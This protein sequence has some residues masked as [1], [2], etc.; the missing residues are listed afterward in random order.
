MSQPN[1]LRASAQEARRRRRRMQIEPIL[2]LEVKALLAPYLPIG[3]RNATFTA[4]DNQPDNQ[5]FGSVN[6]TFGD[7]SLINSAAAYVS[8][9]QLTPISTFNGDIVRIEA[10]P[11]G[12][13]GKSLYAITR[14][15]NTAGPPIETG[16]RPGVIYR[17]DPAT[18]DGNVFF[19]LNT[20]L[21][22]VS[23]GTTA[24]NSA[25][26]ATGLVNWYDITFDETGVFDGLPSMFVSSVD[27]DNPLKNAVY[28][29]APDGTFLGLFIAYGDATGTGS[30]AQRPSAIHVPPPE[31]Q[32]FL[33]G[34]IAGSG[35]NNGNEG[36][37]TAGTTNFTG[38]FFDANIVQGA[39][40]IDA[41]PFPAGVS[42]LNLTL[43]PQVGLTSAN[44]DYGS[45]NYAAFT[46][47]GVPSLSGFSF[48]DPGPSGIQGTAGGL[49]IQNNSGDGVA[50]FNF[51]DFVIGPQPQ[52]TVDLA[53]AQADG[54]QPSGIDRFSAVDTPYR[55]FQDITFDHY[56]YFSYGTTV[57]P[58]DGAL[59]TVGAPVFSGSVF[60]SDLA[61]GLAVPVDLPTV[62]G[63]PTGTIVLPVQ[64]GGQTGVA[65]DPANP[66]GPLQLQFAGG[67]LGGRIIRVLPDGTVTPFAEGFNTTAEFESGSFVESSLSITFSAD[68]TTLYAADNDG[69]WQ[70]KSIM[71][72][73]GSTSGSEVGLNDLRSLGVPFDGEGTAV[74]VVDTGI[75]AS[76]PPLRGHVS[77]GTNISTGG[78]G[79]DD[80]G[81]G[82]GHGTPVAGAI[83][84]FVP[85]TTLVPVNTFNPF[86]AATTNQTVFEAMKYVADNP[87]VNDPLQRGQIDRVVASAFGFGSTS[88]FDTEGTAFRQNKQLVIAYKNQ[89]QRMRRLGI[90][91][92]AAAGQFG[93]PN[94]P[95]IGNVN[96]EALPAILNEAISVTGNYSFPFQTGPTTPPTDPAISPLGRRFGSFALGT[97]GLAD[98]LP[99]IAV[100]D[101]TIFEGRLLSAANRSATTDFAAP[102]LDVPTFRREFAGDGNQHNVF[103]ES[104]TSLSSG[105][106]TGSYTLLASALD[107]YSKL[108]V[109]G[110]TVNSYLTSPVGA[111]ALDYNKSF[112]RDLSAYS[113]P[114]GIN[115]ILQWTAVSI[116]DADLPTDET[117]DAR[118]PFSLAV[119]SRYRDFSR[120]D[121]G[122]AVAAVEGSIAIPYLFST[123]T[124]NLIDSN[125]NGFITAQEIENFVNISETTGLAEAG[126]MARLLGGTARAPGETPIENGRQ[127]GVSS[128][129]PAAPTG[130][131]TQGEQPDQPDVYQRRFNFYDFAADGKLD[132]VVSVKQFELLAHTLLPSPD[133]FTIT[134]RQ[135]GS[136]G[137]YLLDGNP[138]RNYADLQRLLPTY[139]FVPS[140]ITQR[141]RNFSPNKFGVNGGLG[142]NDPSAT[143][144]YALFET[145]APRRNP[146]VD[147]S[148][149]ETPT[150]VTRAQG[151]AANDPGA[152][153]TPGTPL[154]AA[155]KAEDRGNG[156]GLAPNTD[157]LDAV[158]AQVRTKNE[159]LADRLSRLHS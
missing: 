43:G 3:T 156:S 119:P 89:L 24:D 131:T 32:S 108:G 67:N 117:V 64:G 35:T 86:G 1:R 120:V 61:S 113:N 69:I 12:D 97:S 6:V 158:I 30:L 79:D 130:F 28:R 20:V 36:G 125:N 142:V 147:S 45:T 38:L 146:R 115:S 42:Q 47:F 53:S 11:G 26:S 134:D 128:G 18:G 44:T 33:R 95:T 34:L 77:T 88:T 9:S 102:A 4:F 81:P 82:N 8:V 137:G 50:G 25:G 54:T 109:D 123:G 68:G 16:G 116:E 99:P 58:V 2:H 39:Q 154:I 49:L 27:S 93:D 13:F 127:F 52:D 126:S 85:Q 78:A 56:G 80:L 31:Q 84:Q 105:I 29:I 101:L 107:F 118:Q 62:D 59:P 65:I 100:N 41:A 91:P 150:P 92:I 121:I 48:G 5:N 132:G 145:Q 124:I 23:P 19:D 10:G 148:V 143:P 98:T 144:Q 71:S 17:V 151:N 96:G 90:T 112:L 63:G 152:T 103:A 37:F 106:V 157:V 153:Q 14:G 66:G 55:R 139:A 87:F 70:F 111:H 149:A 159:D 110:A 72:L 133:A 122:N 136:A 51:G 138:V 75:D 140:A 74:A 21:N 94:D 83:A 40:L 155:S 114:D 60:V 104:G 57:T 76:T 129:A 7:A 46:D 135:R 73:A 15:T 22:Q 141:Y